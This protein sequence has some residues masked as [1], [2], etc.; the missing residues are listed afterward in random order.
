MSKRIIQPVRDNYDKHDTYANV[1]GRYKKAIDEGFFLEAILIEYAM[2]EDRLRSFVYYLGALN[3]RNSF[4]IDNEGFIECMKDT[5]FTG[6]ELGTSISEI[7]SKRELLSAIAQWCDANK[8]NF[9]DS[10]YLETL[11][12]AFVEEVGVADLQEV[13]SDIKRWCD[14]RNEVIH[15]LF[16]K[17]LD[18]LYTEVKGYLGNGKKYAE[19]LDQLMRTLKKGELR[20]KIN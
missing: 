17:N 6:K 19:Q 8:E 10:D 5:V 14:F 18:S 13:L 20:E 11:K 16:N 4:T 2:L 9:T 7:S 3:D 1:L 12:Y 15:A